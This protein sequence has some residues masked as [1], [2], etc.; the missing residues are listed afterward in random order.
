MLG[1]DV[2][3]FVFQI[4]NF[5]ILLAILG[6]FFYRPVLEVMNRR[7]QAID[8]R[9]SD[10]EERAKKAEEERQAL[11]QQSVEARQQAR[12]LMETAQ[13]DAAEERVRLLEAARAEAASLIDEARKAAAAEQRAALQQVSHRV[14]QSAVNI[15]AALIRG[16]AGQA[17]HIE[18]VRQLLAEQTGLT[19]NVFAT[20]RGSE[21]ADTDPVLI[22]TAYPLADEWQQLMRDQAAKRLGRE[23][24]DLRVEVKLDASLV[25][26]VRIVVGAVAVDMSL[27]HML[28]ELAATMEE[29]AGHGA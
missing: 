4:I 11:A 7:Q 10:A 25:A 14:S 16:T 2:P 3:T 1:F 12:A 6:R 23:P 9:L 5:L 17:I 18:L 8:A 19:G 24:A 29:G 13:R 20:S 15:A 26:G 28:D 21:P 22:E 27:R